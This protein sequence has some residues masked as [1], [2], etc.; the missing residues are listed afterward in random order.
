MTIKELQEVIYAAKFYKE[1]GFKNPPYPNSADEYGI[2]MTF[3]AS[4]ALLLNAAELTMAKA[5][6]ELI[7]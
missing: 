7:V 6:G 5:K 3:A 1:N 2:D 4:Y